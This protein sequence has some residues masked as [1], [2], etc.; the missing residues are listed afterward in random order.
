MGQGAAYKAVR[1]KRRSAARS[2]LQALAG[3]AVCHHQ[4]P[5][6]SLL[7]VT[8]RIDYRDTVA[9]VKREMGGKFPGLQCETKQKGKSH[10]V[11]VDKVRSD[12]LIGLPEQ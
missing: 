6:L 8:D 5:L 2:G 12:E 9:V 10:A 11:S 4:V 1:S 7:I 3:R